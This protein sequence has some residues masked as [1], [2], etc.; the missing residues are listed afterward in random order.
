[1]TRILFACLGNICRSPT[2]EAVFTRMAADAGLSVAVDSCGTGDWHVGDPPDARAIAEA[3]AR[4]YD[5]SRLR[6]RQ[7]RRTDYRDFDLILVMDYANLRD[8]EAQR[9]V[10]HDTP[11]RLFMDFAPETGVAAVPDPY[12]EGNFDRTFELIEAASRGLVAQ[13]LAGSQTSPAVAPK[14]L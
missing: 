4:G 6:A 14:T 3:K 10:G 12:Y 5:M 9:P 1:M 11:V 13:L 2:A 7:F 8:I